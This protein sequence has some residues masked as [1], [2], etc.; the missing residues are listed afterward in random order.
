MTNK[1]I[2]EILEEYPEPPATQ[3]L[4]RHIEVFN[5]EDKG[6]QRANGFANK[7]K[8]LDFTKLRA[9]VLITVQ[10]IEGDEEN[11]GQMQTM[12]F[13]PAHITMAMAANLAHIAMQLHKAEETG[14]YPD[15]NGSDRD[16]RH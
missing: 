8:E 13:G 10:D 4:S 5:D 14:V 3:T 1:T 11:T 16:H 2:D 7:V 9:G 6:R 15:D 12:T